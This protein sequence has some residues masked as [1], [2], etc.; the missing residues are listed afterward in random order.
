ML[1]PRA[2]RLTLAASWPVAQIVAQFQRRAATSIGNL[3]E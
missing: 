2:V 1:H 3:A